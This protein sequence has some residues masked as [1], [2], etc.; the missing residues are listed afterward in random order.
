MR[1]DGFDPVEAA[2]THKV[3]LGGAAPLDSDKMR[4]IGANLQ[5]MKQVLQRP[6]LDTGES[7]PVMH[8]TLNPE[9]QQFINNTPTAFAEQPSPSSI[10]QPFVSTDDVTSNQQEL[11]EAEVAAQVQ[12]LQDTPVTDQLAQSPIWKKLTD[13]TRRRAI[14]S[15]LSPLNFSDLIMYGSVSQDIIIREDYILRLRT[16][17]EHEKLFVLQYLYGLK[18]SNA[19]VD[20]THS[21]LQATCSLERINGKA[22]PTHR[23]H[24]ND[25]AQEEVSPELFEKKLGIVRRLAAPI[26]FDIL[27]QFDWLSE[28][29]HELLSPDNIK[30]F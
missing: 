8:R 19:Y 12:Q 6:E 26:L 10:P 27:I 25:F 21:L 5:T 28:R 29:A 14:E 22:L 11:A 30:N 16:L 13:P 9:V 4:R 23:I 7:P 24:E 3:P 20:A 2:K 15:R 17:K 1:D 18:G